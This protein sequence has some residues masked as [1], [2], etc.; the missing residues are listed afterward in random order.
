MIRFLLLMILFCLGLA[1]AAVWKGQMHHL[2]LAVP[3]SLP[4]WTAPLPDDAGV[5]SGRMKLAAH[6][7]LP[8]TELSW[9]AV[10]PTA[11]GM[12]WDLRLKGRGIDLTAELLLPW[13]PEKAVI[14]GGDG[15]VDLAAVTGSVLEG[16]IAL[17]GIDGEIAGLT[18]AQRISGTLAAR[19]RG[20]SL[21]GAALGGGPV[22]GQLGEDGHWS[23]GLQ[24]SGGLSDGEA[25]IDGQ[26][27]KLSGLLTAAIADAGALPPKARRALDAVST[28]EGGGLRIELPL[29]W[30]R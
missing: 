21:D 27:P 8:A 23:L 5:L 3:D 10:L 25:Q 19:A 29:R 24:L 17:D 2:R 28:P 16:L 12:L 20:L 9:Q 22:T 30:G 7:A 4:G 18:G 26:L 14:R 6:R 15:A 13:W 1:G 11:E